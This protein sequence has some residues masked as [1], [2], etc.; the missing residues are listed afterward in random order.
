MCE[1]KDWP[2][3]VVKPLARLPKD[4]HAYLLLVTIHWLLEK[5]FCQIL[6]R[7][8]STLGIPGQFRWT[9]YEFQDNI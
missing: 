3:F 6:G 9:L 8:G 4:R 7:S 2:G 1:E 5:L